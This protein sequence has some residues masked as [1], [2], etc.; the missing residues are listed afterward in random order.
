MADTLQLL[1][2]MLVALP[3]AAL[4]LA[5]FLW[6][7]RTIVNSTSARASERL[8]WFVLWLLALALGL[9][10]AALVQQLSEPRQLG[11]VPFLVLGPLPVWGLHFLFKRRTPLSSSAPAPYPSL[12]FRWSKEVGLFFRQFK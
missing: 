7:L 1:L 3:I 8:G 11:A 5:V 2:T 4:V 6:P 12:A 10:L 9:F